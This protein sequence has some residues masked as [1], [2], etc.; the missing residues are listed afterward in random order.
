MD[1]DLNP[2]QQLAVSNTEGPLLILA[3]AGS[4]KTRTLTRRA[5]RLVNSGVPAYRVLCITFT[6]KAAQEMKERIEGL[7]G[8]DASQM[9]ILTFHS[10]C[11]RILRREAQAAGFAPAFAV[12]DTDD[13]TRLLKQVMR[14]EGVDE[15]RFAPRAVLAA[16]SDAKN[17]LRSPGE[18]ANDAGAD[19]F[20]G[21]C[22]TLYAAYDKALMRNNAMDFDDLLRHAVRLFEREPDILARYA[23]R[24]RYIHVDEY[25]D[26]NRAQYLLV[27]MLAA[28]GNLCVVGDDDQ[29]IYG[30]RGADI[31]NI[32]DFER[33]FPNATVIRLEQNYRSTK[34]ILD[35]ANA[36]ITHNRARKGKNLWSEREGGAPVCVQRFVSER[37][38]ALFVAD[39]VVALAREY[40]PGDI[41]VLYRT[42]AQSRVVEEA[43]R[44]HNI[45][46]RMVGGQKFYERKEIRDL[47][48]YLRVLLNP[49]D[50]ISLSRIINVP[51]RGIGET[52]LQR[53]L[54][55]AGQSGLSLWETVC[56]ASEH[57]IPA[58]AADKL[59]SFAREMIT[60]MAKS[61]LLEP[62]AYVRAV[63]ETT[64]L[65]AQYLKD[66]SIEAQGRAENVMEFVNAVK[67]YFEEHPDETMEEYLNGLMLLADV[68]GYD[69]KQNAVTLMTLHS[70]KGLEFRAVF[71]IGLEEGLCPHSRCVND[72]LAVEEE[73]RLCYV[74]FTRAMDRLYLTYALSRGA[75]GTTS[76]NPPSRFLAELPEQGVQRD[77]LSQARAPQ[78]DAFSRVRAPRRPIPVRPPA[79]AQ[80]DAA[81]LALEAGDRVRHPAF[82]GG[83][84]L[85]VEGSG[86]GAVAQI[87]FGPRGV[88]RIMLKYAAMKKV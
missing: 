86:E 72:E 25:Q 81:L 12:Y 35:A 47:V 32:L 40:A 19:M 71:F 77:D 6:N 11:L 17:R 15:K 76:H 26:T 7:L 44:H 64:G 48:A 82:G 31:R 60:L 85:A 69:E 34:P 46:Y 68:D 13:Q 66:G 70:A 29:S 36:L 88:K 3:G 8:A 56:N 49:D 30:W 54:Q 20:Y 28:H 78:E 73:R 57:G 2:M 58:R 37:D 65:M 41:A 1:K 62:E 53:L 10:L 33:D 22:A 24:F 21:T 4:G 45:A 79:F 52:T 14:H 42:N 27:R 5:A 67:D 39:T 50:G 63:I 59:A 23:R 55:A 38:E 83:E 43:F 51:R 80:A 16:I 87:D 9:W 61:Q 18:M 74:G 75:Y 84:V